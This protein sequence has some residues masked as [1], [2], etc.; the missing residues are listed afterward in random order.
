MFQ[1]ELRKISELPDDKLEAW[2]REFQGRA[3]GGNDAFNHHHDEFKMAVDKLRLNLGEAA[4]DTTIIPDA[5]TNG[6][7]SPWHNLWHWLRGR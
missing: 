6:A 4:N 2:F 3:K 7:G 1:D 5:H